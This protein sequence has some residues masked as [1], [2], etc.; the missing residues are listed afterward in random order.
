MLVQFIPARELG[1]RRTIFIFQ[2][3]PQPDFSVKWSYPILG[4]LESM[5]TT[6]LMRSFTLTPTQTYGLSLE[7][8]Q[9]GGF[10]HLIASK[11]I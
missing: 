11:E 8:R 5:L 7:R 2:V 6:S 4:L 10:R 9:D 1:G 3:T